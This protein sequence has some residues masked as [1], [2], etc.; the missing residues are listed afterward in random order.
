MR[1]DPKSDSRVATLEWAPDLRSFAPLAHAAG[2]TAAAWSPDSTRLALVCAEGAHRHLKVR[3]LRTGADRALAEFTTAVSPP[4]WSPDGTRVAFQAF[5]PV[6]DPEIGTRLSPP[7][8]ATWASPYR[9]IER[10]F[11]RADGAGLLPSGYMQTFVSPADG[12][13]SARQLTSGV[14]WSLQTDMAWSRDG[15]EIYFVANRRPDWDR[16][17][18][19]V[20]LYAVRV[21]D[22]RVRVVSERAGIAGAVAPSPDGKWLA[23]LAVDKRT[24]SNQNLEIHLQPLAGGAERVLAAS[25]DRSIAS[26]VWASDSQALFAS[27]EDRGQ[28]MLARVSLSGGLRTLADDVAGGVIELPFGSVFGGGE[29]SVARDGS[30]AYVRSRASEPPQ[31]A[32]LDAR[33]H[34]STVTALNARVAAAIGGFLPATHFTL[35]ASTD[36]LPLDAWLIL[37]RGAS[38]SHR[39]PVILDIHG[40]P[41]AA[42]GDR[43]SLK[44]QLF[45]AAGYAVLYAN[46]R[47]S[48]GYGEAFANLIN[49][50]WPGHDADDLLD[51]IAAATAAHTELDSR[52]VFATGTSGGATMTIVLAARGDRIRAGVA[53]KPLVNWTS[54]LLD[55][56]EGT[57]TDLSFTHPPVVGRFPWVDPATYWARSPLSLAPKVHAPLLLMAG[58]QDLRTPESE[59]IQMYTALKLLGKDTALMLGPGVSHDSGAYRPSLFLQECLATLAWFDRHRAPAER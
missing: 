1:R 49:D 13:A 41:Y 4:V 9:V 56:D 36:G 21:A 52:N 47:G 14:W 55:A 27:Y 40:G 23:Y 26:M 58:D 12:S 50:A 59:A 45:A 32:V 8:G 28:V 46:Q 33:R 54:W 38:A 39:V 30:V 6:P 16:R 18:T 19:D 37:P 3:D 48:S 20:G 35:R 31:V 11:F 17:A 10:T 44:Y 34:E 7:P 29:F 15:T 25:L 22:A 5:V 42:V 24:P 53:V 51:V 2:C 57:T 43:F